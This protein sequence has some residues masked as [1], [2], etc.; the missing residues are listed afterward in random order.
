MEDLEFPEQ[1]VLEFTCPRDLLDFIKSVGASQ[2]PETVKAEMWA[3]MQQMIEEQRRQVS[4]WDGR[5]NR[6]ESRFDPSERAFLPSTNSELPI[7]IQQTNDAQANLAKNFKYEENDSKR[8][9][10]IQKLRQKEARQ[11]AER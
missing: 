3:N 11:A 10:S 8:Q 6:S 1:Q 7:D 5:Y 9:S 4:A 2:L